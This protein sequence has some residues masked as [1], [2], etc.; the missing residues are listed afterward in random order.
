M[1]SRRQ[2]VQGSAL[3]LAGCSALKSSGSGQDKNDS[4]DYPFRL[5]VASGDPTSDAVVLWTR[6]APELLSDASL[7]SAV[8][9]SWII[10][11]DPDLQR[12]ADVGEVIA[13]PANAHCVHVD[14]GGLDPDTFYYYQFGSTRFKSPIGRTRTLP[15]P[16]IQLS[17]F[18]IGLTSCQEY[19]QGYF[20]AFRDLIAKQPNIVIHNGDY[21]YEAPSGTI[22]PYPV[23]KEAQTLS[24]YRS[25]YAQYRQDADLRDAHAQFPWFVIWDDHEVVNDWGPDHYLPSSRN[26]L[27]SLREHRLRKRAATKAFLEHMPLRAAMADKDHEQPIFYSKSVIG[28]L[29]EISHLDVRSYRDSPV[30]NEVNGMRFSD[31]SDAHSAD[32]SMLGD[33]QEQWL[34]DSFGASGCRWNCISQTS[35]MAALDRAAGPSVSYETDSW[36]NY[37]ANRA[38]ILDHIHRNKIRN[39]VSLGGNIHAF[40]AGVVS[41]ESK[42]AQCDPILME[43]ITTSITAT[44]GDIERFRDIQGRRDENPCISFFENR[45]HGYTFLQFTKERLTASFRMVDD[46]ETRN[47]SFSTLA[48]MLIEDGRP[49]VTITAVDELRHTA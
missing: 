2:F 17:E 8:S 1:I 3:A 7:T 44:G 33:V 23:E 38:R 29:L 42:V 11:R 22:R 13:L 12:V 37:P 31:C 47:G 4:K 32:R 34:Y 10:A 19:S 28:D 20:S 24:E 36:D 30:C 14:V 39:A 49:G 25:L 35:I 45:Y 40:Y 18:A 6:L 5:G 43:L 41:D 15:S 9:V 26:E 48:T 16:G 27:L 46:I 21:I